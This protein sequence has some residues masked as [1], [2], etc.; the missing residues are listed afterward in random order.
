MGRQRV[1]ELSRKLD[2]VVEKI[3]SN[4]WLDFGVLGMLITAPVY[5][6]EWS[7]SRG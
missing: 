7:I 4:S 1:G 5:A 2:A 6:G 3:G